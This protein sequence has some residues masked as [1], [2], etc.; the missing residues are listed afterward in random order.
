MLTAVENIIKPNF[1]DIPEEIKKFPQ[2]VLWKAE[3]VKGRLSKVPYQPTGYKANATDSNTWNTFEIIQKA[4]ETGKFDGIGFVFSK[5]D[6]FVGIDLDNEDPANLSTDAL[7]LSAYSYTELSPSGNGLHIIMKGSLPESANN[8]KDNKEIYDKGRYFTFTGKFVTDKPILSNQKLIDRIVEKYF[9]SKKKS[10]NQGYAVDRPTKQLDDDTVLSKMFKSKNGEKIAN[11]FNGSTDYTSDSEADLA[12]CNYLAYWTDGNSEQM[13]RLFRR[14]A[15]IRDK[16]DKKIA[17][18]T[19]GWMTIEKAI[20][21]TIKVNKS[22]ADY[23][24]TLQLERNKKGDKILPNSR[25]AETILTN[26][27]FKGILAFDAFKNI[28]AIKGDLPWRKRERPF[29][30]YEAWLGSDDKRLLHYFGK[31][32]DFRSANIIQNAYIEVT[33]QNSFHPV[34]EYLE[35]QVW[36]KSSRVETFFIDYLG[37]NN[38]PYIR[39]V[40]RKW[41]VAAVARIYEPGCKFDYMPVLV[42]P[43]GVGKSSTIAKLAR[44][45]FSDSLKN[46]E[47]KEAGEHLQNSWI[48]EFGELAGMKKAEV[49]EIKAFISKREDTYRVAYDRVVSEFPR[50]CVFIGT[51]NTHDFLRDQTGNRRFWPVTVDTKKRKYN[52][53]T[54]LTDDIVGQIWAEAMEL[55]KQGEKLYLEPAMEEEARKVQEGHMEQDP[56]TGAIEE[57]LE[58]PLPANWDTMQIWERQ[59]YLT[60]KPTGTIKRERVCPAEVWTECMGNDY[61]NMKTHEARA[62]ADIIRKLDGWEERKPSRTTFKHYGKQTTFIRS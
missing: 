2:W 19:Y 17:G 7:T 10:S 42:G 22:I 32:Y 30:P 37:A 43:Q 51:T 35:S 36:D 1:N 41:L 34:K 4:Y 38:T 12:L 44:E 55:Y 52:P 33:R 9:G 47:S 31:E 8:R 49:E 40:T 5:N 14:S 62:I 58:K 27:P 24:D 25:N 11:L 6:P 48:F 39:A 13:D 26:S 16:W 54:D 61:R 57:Y 15:L 50:K 3:P 60:H 23:N 46:F 45:W 56:R 29:Q 53:I 59:N 18:S 28:E 21:D 20:S